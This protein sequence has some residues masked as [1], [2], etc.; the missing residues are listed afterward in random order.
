MARTYLDKSIRASEARTAA[1]AER[2][3]KAYQVAAQLTRREQRVNREVTAQNIKIP[4]LPITLSDW[5][6]ASI[7]AK[8]LA[9]EYAR[10]METMGAGGAYLG[11]PHPFLSTEAAVETLLGRYEYPFFM[12]SRFVQSR[13]PGVVEE[14]F[15]TPESIAKLYDGGIKYL[16]AG[17][18]KLGDE[19]RARVE[20]LVTFCNDNITISPGSIASLRQKS[21]KSEMK[22]MAWVENTIKKRAAPAKGL[23]TL[24][25][26]T[27]EQAKALEDALFY[28]ALGPALRP[29]FRERKQVLSRLT[30]TI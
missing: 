7:E 3:A 1:I 18:I 24:K 26:L 9:F 21:I 22:D 23:R 12:S 30:R 5:L 8:R 15:N 2:L 14:N 13:V 27:A 11:Q 29:V 17:A 28:R 20:C 25:N 16:K 10:T 4:S 19:A 6:M